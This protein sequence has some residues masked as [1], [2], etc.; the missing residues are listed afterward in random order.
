[1]N[2]RAQLNIK[3]D[4]ELL[5]L[6]KRKA[7]TSS[8]NMGDYVNNLLKCYLT[9]LEIRNYL[10]KRTDKLNKIENKLLKAQKLIDHIIIE[11]KK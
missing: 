11:N 5:K 10:I 1:M 7:L 6:V 4:K 9:N 3:I 8:F 2:S